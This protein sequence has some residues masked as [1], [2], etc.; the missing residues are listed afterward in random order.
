MLFV[1]FFNL[2]G[3]QKKDAPVR[4]ILSRLFLPNLIISCLT[5]RPGGIYPAGP[6]AIQWLSNP[7]AFQRVFSW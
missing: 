6:V 2:P 7:E 3:A 5:F 4:D 1:N